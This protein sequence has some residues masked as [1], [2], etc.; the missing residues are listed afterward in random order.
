MRDPTE[1]GAAQTETVS[2][3][4]PTKSSDNVMSSEVPFD[5]CPGIGGEGGA[6]S[7]WSP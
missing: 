2:P 4:A 6:T 3:L 5:I 7:P 1:N